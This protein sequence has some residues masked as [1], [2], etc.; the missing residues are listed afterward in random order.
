MR[1]DR[2]KKLAKVLVTYSTKVKPGDLVCVSAEDGCLPF[3]KEVSKAAIQA[4]GIVQP[5]VDFPEIDEF[6][7]KNGH[8]LLFITFILIKRK[9][10]VIQ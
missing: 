8:K 7:L 3:I 5:L 9:G 6:L 10:E 4:G 1:D 2:L